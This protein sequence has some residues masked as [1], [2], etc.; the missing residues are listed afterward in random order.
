MGK[1][2][3][4]A[5]VVE[6]FVRLFLEGDDR[7]VDRCFAQNP[8]LRDELEHKARIINSLREGLQDEVWQGRRIGEYVILEEL[9]RGGMGIVFL[10]I[11]PSLDRYVALKILPG[12]IVLDTRMIQRFRSEAKIIARFNQP[13][14][15][16]IY[17]TGEDQG[18]YYIAMGYVPGVSLNKVIELLGKVPSA[19]IDAAIVRDIIGKAPSAIRT[20]GSSRGGI[21]AERPD[22]FWKKSYVEFVVAIATEIADALAYAHRNGIYHGDLKPSNIIMSSTGVPVVAD[23]GLSVEAGLKGESQSLQLGGTVPYMAP[24]QIEGHEINA[25][26]DVWSFGVVM[27]ELLT[28]RHPFEGGAASRTMHRVLTHEPRLMRR[29]N[30]AIPRNLEAIVSKCLE[31]DTNDRYESIPDACK[32]ISDFLGAKP[33]KAKPVGAAVRMKRWI[34]RHP[35]EAALCFVLGAVMLLAGLAVLDW[36][37]V[38][39]RI[40]L[41][42]SYRDGEQHDRALIL[43]DKVERLLAWWPLSKHRLGKVL[44]GKAKAYLGMAELRSMEADYDKAAEYFLMAEGI[45]SARPKLFNKYFSS[46]L[47][48]KIGDLCLTIGQHEKAAER[49]EKVLKLGHEDA[50]ALWRLVGVANDHKDY[51]KAL[52]YLKRLEELTPWASNVY[53]EI[54]RVWAIKGDQGKVIYYLEKALELDPENSSILT[55]LALGLQLRGS[56]E[57]TLQYLERLQSVRP[58]D[59]YPPWMIGGIWSQLGNQEEAIKYYS[60]AL[61]L[62]PH[63]QGS[64]WAMYY[65][66]TDRNS[67]DE[68]MGYLERL[69]SLLP[70][71]QR[72]RV[73]TAELFRSK[74][75][76]NEAMSLYREALEI[77]TGFVDVLKPLASLCFEQGEY[78]QAIDYMKRLMLKRPADRDASFFIGK[79]LEAKGEYQQAVDQYKSL[80]QDNPDDVD[81][82]YTL[83]E[84][85]YERGFYDDAM[86]SL[87]RLETLIPTESSVHSDMAKVWIAKGERLEAMSSYKRALRLNPNDPSL[88]WSVVELAIRESMHDEALDC[89]TVLGQTSPK[90]KYVSYEIANIYTAKGDYKDAVYHYKKTL[91]LDPRDTGTLWALTSLG[92]QRGLYD[93]A[94][95]YVNQIKA[96]VPTE[97]AVDITLGNILMSK[98]EFEKASEHYQRALEVDPEGNDVL[99]GLASAAYSQGLYGEALQYL[100]RLK[101]LAPKDTYVLLYLGKCASRMGTLDEAMGYLREA[102]LLT[103]ADV[104]IREEVV[105][106]LQKKG[107]REDEARSYL[108]SMGFDENQIGS[109]MTMMN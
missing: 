18:V 64:L 20:G 41:A 108:G 55:S 99:H 65:T 9:G 29:L 63:H 57:E 60:R 28:L 5:Q 31:K 70:R 27:Y 81:T 104:E 102:L 96:I 24:E 21:F 50:W 67:Y 87:V 101:E 37:L 36:R 82:L 2:K 4:Q 6:S 56:F 53:S 25:Q 92:M 100:R 49:Y 109:V 32:D 79:A 61:E 75:E 47:Q 12:G 16:P 89:L 23:F 80:L 106:I 39:N 10:A 62:D 59:P 86:E 107:L 22:T 103:P 54:G 94:L 97:K 93:E 52:S 26:T 88:L 84:V 43:Y 17:S 3:E 46:K 34:K 8:E 78:G 58:M 1:S 66:A 72:V 68:A 42:N 44:P 105:F 90:D 74:G 7:E 45:V 73:A 77:D 13:N 11:Q 76:L 19:D 40:N 95:G 51:D 14:I 35:A 33:T 85:A 83:A 48:G 71:S 91:E 30:R 38:G 69:K 15:V 98:G